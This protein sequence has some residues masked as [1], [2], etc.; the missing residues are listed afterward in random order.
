MIEIL[1]PTRAHSDRSRAISGHYAK[2]GVSCT[3]QADDCNSDE[4]V[5]RMLV[6]SISPYIAIHGDDDLLTFAFIRKALSFSAVGGVRGHGVTMDLRT[7]ACGPYRPSPQSQCHQ[8]S[9]WHRPT[10]LEIYEEAKLVSWF[11]NER[12]CESAASRE[13]LL[14]SLAAPVLK[15]IETLSVFRGIH[16]G[17]V[18][19]LVVPIEGPQPKKRQ[20][21]IS[22][23]WPLISP[24]RIWSQSH[25]AWKTAF[26][27]LREVNAP[28]KP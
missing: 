23:L 20:I 15:E 12:T 10:L 1:I 16:P 4:S 14:S 11:W 25:A 8:F 18:N 3:V 27:I 9:V 26:G 13:L 2:L 21:K 7:G 24:Q 17:R 19:R 22:R 6:R 5:R 28:R